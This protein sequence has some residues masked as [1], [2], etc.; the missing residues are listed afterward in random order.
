MASFLLIPDFLYK[1]ITLSCSVT[2][3][4]ANNHLIHLIKI[5]TCPVHMVKFEEDAVKG[6]FSYSSEESM[7]C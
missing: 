3:D 5:K 1:Y 4:G 7:L 2:S 6:R